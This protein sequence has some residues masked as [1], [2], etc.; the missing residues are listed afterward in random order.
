[1]TDISVTASAVVLTSGPAPTQGTAGATITAGQPVALNASGLYVPA[2]S[3]NA[4]AL[5]RVAVGIALCGASNGQPLLVANPGSL[6]TLNAV[7]TASEP[8]FLS[9]TAGGIA[10]K[11]DIA[12]GMYTQFLG[13]ANSTTVLNF[14]PCASSAAHA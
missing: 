6:I 2:D 11:A 9:A 7:L 1:M 8:Y 3:D 10:P 4:T 14:N 5:L 12:T 13:M